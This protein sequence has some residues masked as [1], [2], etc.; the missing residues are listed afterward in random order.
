MKIGLKQFWGNLHKK[1]YRYR[2]AV[3]WMFIAFLVILAEPDWFGFVLGTGL[4]IPGIMIRFWASGYVKKNRLLE[5]RGPYTF[6]RHPQYLGNCLIA[7][8][9]CFASSHLWAIGVLA[10]LFFLLYVPAIR[11]ED[12]RL[13][14]HFGE[15]WKE[16]YGKT[17]AIVPTHWPNNN[18]SLH[19]LD[20]SFSQSLRNG[21][22]LWMFF[23]LSGL[24]SIYLRLV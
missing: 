2:Q 11:R 16:W 8:G 9:I 20:W 4:Y 14:K 24:L 15:S 7:S 5:K 21:E 12:D 6:V 13:S 1:R 19:L 10:V 17:S 18:P 23:L 22:P 3:G